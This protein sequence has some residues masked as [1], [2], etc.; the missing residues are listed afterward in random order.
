MEDLV[1]TV[2]IDEADSE[3][4]R[5]EGQF[6]ADFKLG[7]GLLVDIHKGL[8]FTLEKQKIN[9]EVWLTKR[10]SGQGKASF[11]VFILRVHGRSAADMSDY[12]KFQTGVTILPGSQVI[13]DNGAPKPAEPV[14]PVAPSQSPK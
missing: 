5:A 3:I 11:G 14:P 9:D 4:A 6:L 8:S 12:R 13:D 2:W 1:G 10:V 7:F